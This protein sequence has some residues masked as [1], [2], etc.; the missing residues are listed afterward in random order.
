MN[1]VFNKYMYKFVLVLLYEILIYSKNEEEHEEH[2]RIALQ[3]LRDNKLCENLR[4]CDFYK[5]KIHY[6]GHI[7]SGKGI[8]V[9][10]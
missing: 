3:F 6:L 10:P 5:D 2:L 9:D 4:K 7:I 8:F 1:S